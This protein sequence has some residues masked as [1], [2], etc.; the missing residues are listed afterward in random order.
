MP[1][2]LPPLTS[3]TLLTR[4]GVRE[5]LRCSAKAARAVLANVEPHPIP[6][7]GGEPL[8]RWRWGDILETSPRYASDFE[9]GVKPKPKQRLPRKSLR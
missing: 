8:L 3:D 4:D 9:R 5:A 2:S 6:V 1:S 7:P